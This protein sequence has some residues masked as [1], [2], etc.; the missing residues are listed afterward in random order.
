MV[1]HLCLCNTFI[2]WLNS[3]EDYFESLLTTFEA[4][5]IFET[6]EAITKNWIELRQSR[7]SVSKSLI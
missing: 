5:S 7:F 2:K 6:A 3:R 1:C 4:S